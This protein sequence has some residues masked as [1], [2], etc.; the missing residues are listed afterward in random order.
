MGDLR[1]AIALADSKFLK[2][3]VSRSNLF[4]RSEAAPGS[5]IRTRRSLHFRHLRV[6]EDIVPTV[7]LL[8]LLLLPGLA[9]ADEPTISVTLGNDTRTFTRGELLVRPDAAT[10]D[11]ARDVTYRVLMTYRAVPVASLLAGMTLPPDSVIE[12]VA[13]DGFI[14]QLPSDLIVRRRP[15]PQPAAKSDRI[16]D[17]SGAARPDPQPWSRAHM[18]GD[19]H[20]AV[21]AGPSERPRDRAHRCISEA[22][23]WQEAGTVAFASAAIIGTRA[24]WS[25]PTCPRFSS[26][27]ATPSPRLP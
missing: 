4:Q 22:Y 14:A 2:R 16:P 26:L 11:V 18:A 3:L 10:I 7:L 5:T 23:G 20:A 15:G 17:A 27:D 21:S 13:L 25:K 1:S 19:G 24:A 12:A 6:G 9:H 8:C